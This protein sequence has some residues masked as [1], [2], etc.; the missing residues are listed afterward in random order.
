MKD[1]TLQDEIKDLEELLEKKRAAIPRHSIR[2]YQL[3]EI[4]E[5]EDDLMELIKR[6]EI[7]HDSRCTGN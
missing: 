4:E 5:M 3:L 7:S 2:P 6:K 1:T